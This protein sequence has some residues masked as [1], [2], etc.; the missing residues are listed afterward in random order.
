MELLLKA[1]S[2][3]RVLFNGEKVSN[4]NTKEILKYH[5]KRL[6]NGNHTNVAELLKIKLEADNNMH[7]ANEETNN[8][9]LEIELI[10]CELRTNI[11]ILA[12]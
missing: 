2:A 5:L 11:R 7:L 1:S 12:D 9:I 8:L 4:E 10:V 6:R 3:R